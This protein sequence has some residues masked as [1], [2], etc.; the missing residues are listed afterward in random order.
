MLKTT[1][2]TAPSHAQ[3]TQNDDIDLGVLVGV[4]V[5]HRWWIATIVLLFIVGGVGYALLAKPIYQA[6]AMVQVEPKAAS[7]PGLSDITEALGDA[8]QQAA[9][10]IALITSRRVL[11]KVNEELLLNVSVLP[12]QFP[13]VGEVLARRHSRSDAATLAP[14]MWGLDSYAWGGE[15]LEFATFKEVDAYAARDFVLQAGHRG[16]FRLTENGALVLEGRIGETVRANGLTVKVRT[17]RARSGTQFDVGLLPENAVIDNLRRALAVSERAKDSGILTMTLEMDDPALAARVL[18]AI[19][20]RYVRH[21]VERNS[22]EAAAS[23]QFVKEQLPHVRRDL[24]KAENEFNAYQ[25]RAH[26]VDI[27]LETKA[28]LDQIVAI[29]ASLSEL[30]MQ[31][32]DME[33]RFTPAHPAYQAMQRQRAELEGKKQTFSDKVTKL[34]EMQQELL[35][36]KRG[37]EVGTEIY[38]TLLNQSQQ[39]ALAQAGTVGNV[40]VVDEASADPTHPIRPRRARIVLLATALGLLVGVVTVLLRRM[41]QRGVETVAAIEALDFSVYASIPLSACSVKALRS[42]RRDRE[43]S[44]LALE[45]GDDLAMEGIRSLRTS[46]HFA[47]LEAQ[48]NVLMIGG[49]S[50]GVGKSFVCENLAAA[51]AQTGQ[52]VLLV[53]GDMRRGKVHRTMGMELGRGMSDLLVGSAKLDDA[54]RSSPVPGLDFISRGKVPPNP[55]ELFM[56]V[57]L[58]TCLAQMSQRYDI[59]VI[60]TTPILAVTDSAIIGRHAGTSLLVA[61]FALTT[62]KELALARQRL[63][64]NGVEVKGVIFNAV[65]KRVGNLYLYGYEYKSVDSNA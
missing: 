56:H 20:Q 4:L 5:D 6:Q 53:D 63:V 61:R 39:L 54:I 13:L 26:S 23:L 10:E 57:N 15:K 29:D 47:M 52:R 58:T 50:P 1:H 42:R 45:S 46:L 7:L 11:G 2:A 27:T 24:E 59:V 65:K 51:I 37:V 21:N 36:L 19:V 12:R 38:T 18:K 62:T 16:G 48:N 60:D 44:L 8:D 41:L 34:P 3:A 14:A 43:P 35:R 28:I 9:T 32:A 64:Q 17:L 55:S 40:H 22:A 33:R 31:H 25:A 49:A 30:K